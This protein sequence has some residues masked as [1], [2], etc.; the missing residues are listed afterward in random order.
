MEVGYYTSSNCKVLF[1][2]S[3]SFLPTSS[4]LHCKHVKALCPKSKP[5]ERSR[6]CCGNASGTKVDGVKNTMLKS[7][8]LNAR[9]GSGH[10]LAYG[11][12][13][14]HNH[15]RPGNE[16]TQNVRP[17]GVDVALVGQRFVPQQPV[18]YDEDEEDRSG[19]PP[20]E[21]PIESGGKPYHVFDIVAEPLRTLNVKVQS[22]IVGARGV[23]TVNPRNRDG[24]EEDR[25]E[26][27]V[28]GRVPVQK[29]EKVEASLRARRQP[30]EEVQRKQRG[31]EQFPVATDLREFVAERGYDSL[32]TAKLQPQFVLAFRYLHAL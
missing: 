10:E 12:R 6:V 19:E 1:T 8:H 18:D 24:L 25:E 9:S 26:H 23:F 14:Y 29:M 11:H 17:R 28:P 7:A 2:R 32:R 31:H 15:R 22:S 5:S 21:P 4:Q 3:T 27:R 13:G 16:P 20:A 30:H